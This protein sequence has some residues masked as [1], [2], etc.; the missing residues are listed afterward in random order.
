MKKIIKLVFFLL[1]T[2]YSYTQVEQV[3]YKLSTQNNYNYTMA[4]CVEKGNVVNALQFNSQVSLVSTDSIKVISDIWKITTKYE[5]K[6]F[7]V[8]P[9]LNNRNIYSSIQEG[10]CYDLF[11]IK[12]RNI[13]LWDNEKDP[14]SVTLGGAQFDNGFTI[15]STKQL[16]VGNIHEVKKINITL[17]QI[18]NR[19][20]LLYLNGQMK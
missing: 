5:N 13:R 14:E 17:L 12:G 6:Y 7:S 8:T 1:L 19:Y 20:K 18:D 11:S 16:Y 4:F 2:Q 9:I 15:G 3:V 10:K